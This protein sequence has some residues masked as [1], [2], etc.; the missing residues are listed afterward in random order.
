ML[1][2]PA[3]YRATK[4]LV[5]QEHAQLQRER[6]YWYGQGYS[7]DEAER[8]LQPLMLQ[9]NERRQELEQ[10]ERLVRGD[11]SALGQ[12]ADIGVALTA[13]RLVR[14]WTQR[15]LADHLD[16]DESQVSRDESSQYRNAGIE[17]L[18][19]VA[20]VLGLM[21]ECRFRLAQPL[22]ATVEA[23]TV[24]VTLRDVSPVMRLA[25]AASVTTLVQEEVD[26]SR[27]PQ[28]AGT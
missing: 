22:R 17:R 25:R 10:Y 27:L 2:T 15:Q 18:Q 20:Q 26:P 8:M 23:P 13:A 1:R 4:A 21:V 19:R 6:E 7:A 3:E 24:R 14:Q 5:E 9:L 11:F 16:V 28:Y 12:L